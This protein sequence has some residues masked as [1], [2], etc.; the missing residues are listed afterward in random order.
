T[1]PVGPGQPETSRAAS[2][3]IA[4]TDRR[5]DRE[6]R[7]RFS[8]GGQIEAAGLAGAVAAGRV[9]GDLE[10]GSE[11]S[12]LVPALRLA[13]A[14][15]LDVAAEPPVG[16]AVLRWSLASFAGCPMKVSLSR[17]AYLRP[18]IEL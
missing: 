6:R 1:S 11:A 9:F 17:T 16:T 2:A 14:R 15:S 7:T 18:C 4:R 3:D 5:P 10:I 13:F 12:V 8:A